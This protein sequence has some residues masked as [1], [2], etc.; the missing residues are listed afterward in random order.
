MIVVVL[1][2]RVMFLL[3]CLPSAAWIG[4][5]VVKKE[6]KFNIVLLTLLLLL[7]TRLQPRPLSCC[8][9]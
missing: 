8:L 7:I 9:L 1:F 2:M 3:T 4:V 5:G 6:E